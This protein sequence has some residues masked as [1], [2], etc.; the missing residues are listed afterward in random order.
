MLLIS[1]TKF[2]LSHVNYAGKKV[3]IFGS[4]APDTK[5]SETLLSSSVLQRSDVTETF[6]KLVHSTFD[7][8][9]SNISN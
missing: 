9:C 2:H 5:S 6:L 8:S 4:F 7:D 3:L 1:D